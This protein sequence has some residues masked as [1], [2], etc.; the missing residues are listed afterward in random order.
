MIKNSLPTLAELFE[1]KAYFGHTSKLTH[2]LARS[3]IY[4]KKDGFAILDLE[5]TMDR[6]KRAGDYLE[7][8]KKK[9]GQVLFLGAKPQAAAFLRE[10]A[11][12]AKVP[13]L[14]KRWIGGF[15]T[16]FETI[17]ANLK[18]IEELKEKTK[19]ETLTK[20]ERGKMANK[21]VG[22]EEKYSGLSGLEKIPDALVVIDPLL[23]KAA[24][25]EAKALGVPVLAVDDGKTDP[26]FFAYYVPVNDDSASS[27]S[28]VIDYLIKRASVEQKSKKEKDEKKNN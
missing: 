8:V 11:A 20:R 22:L 18:K 19:D 21:V 7:E 3:F 9:G 12:K 13:F 26:R 28:L 5:K 24:I 25:E 10:K 15:L 27:L 17:F 4:V 6:L 1:A 14:A 23:E 2:P 16:N